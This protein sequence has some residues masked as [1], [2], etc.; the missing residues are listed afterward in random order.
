MILQIK[1]YDTLPQEAID[2]RTEIF[3]V[4]QGFQIEFD[5]TDK[6]AKHLVVFDKNGKAVATCRFFK[7]ELPGQYILGR[8][9]VRKECRGMDL[10]TAML[11]RTEEEVRK[12]GGK[13][14]DLHAQVRAG[15]FYEQQGYTAYGDEVPEDG[16][17]HVWMRK[18]L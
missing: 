14:I 7:G 2:I 5:E 3:V 6:T 11:L 17:P 13:R 4:E 10:G 8:V 1:M 18:D 12:L 9:C 16:V 15:H